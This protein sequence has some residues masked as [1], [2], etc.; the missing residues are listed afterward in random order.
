MPVHP[1]GRY[2]YNSVIEIL[3]AERGHAWKPLPCNRLDRLTSG[4]MFIGKHARAAEA[5]SRQIMARDVRKEYVARVRGEFPAGEVACE[6]PMLA[7]SPKLGLNRVRA[8]GKEA[9]TVF[10]R[11]A[12]RLPDP[13]S[14]SA[15]ERDGF[16]IVRCRPL[17]GRTHQIRVH[18]QFLGHPIA[19]DPIYSNARV[20]GPD[21]G[22]GDGT[23][24]A[25]EDVISRLSRMGKSEA[26]VSAAVAFHDDMVADYERKKAEKLTGDV[27]PCAALLSTRTRASTSWASTCTPAA[28]PATAGPAR[29]GLLRPL[30]PL[31]PCCPA[32]TRPRAS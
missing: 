6:Q 7:I 16:S 12:H 29:A 21:L 1:A 26:A 23:A 11:L 18:L 10:H 5:I 30:C 28:T 22:R 2:N 8:N 14:A 31:G 27:A 3:R 13:A 24:D 25:D 4:V 32:T 15:E 20:F 17:T 19:N 9:R